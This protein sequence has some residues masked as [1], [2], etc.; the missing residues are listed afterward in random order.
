MQ[1]VRRGQA[2]A[3]KTPLAKFL[4]SWRNM[5]LLIVLVV[6]VFVAIIMFV[7]GYSYGFGEAQNEYFDREGF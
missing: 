2:Q 6:V 3:A 7:L 4:F 5:N 1:Q